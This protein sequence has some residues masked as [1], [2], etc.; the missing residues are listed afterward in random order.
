MTT[1]ENAIRNGVDT[2]TLFAT[3]DAVKGDTDLAKFQFR[4]TNRWRRRRCLSTA[5]RGSSPGQYQI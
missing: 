3:L 5:H 2:A 1:T 4:A